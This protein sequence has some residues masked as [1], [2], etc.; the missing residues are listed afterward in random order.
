MA[1]EAAAF[2]S[3]FRGWIR[4]V[5]VDDDSAAA[6]RRFFVLQRRAAAYLSEADLNVATEADPTESEPPPSTKAPERLARAA[7]EQL[8]KDPSLRASLTEAGYAPLVAWAS[9]RAVAAAVNLGGTSTAG[10]A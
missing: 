8:D 2:A 10:M 7:L 5:P 9:D 6:A 4:Q 1:D 3:M